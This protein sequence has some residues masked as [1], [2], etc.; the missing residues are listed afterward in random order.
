MIYWVIV[1]KRHKKLWTPRSR[2]DF[3]DTVFATKEDAEDTMTERQKRHY[4][5]ISVRMGK[6]ANQN[7]P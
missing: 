5:V 1:S 4:I 7:E 2:D 6:E 3:Y